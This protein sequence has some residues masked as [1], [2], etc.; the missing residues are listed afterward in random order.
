MSEVSENSSLFFPGT[1]LQKAWDSTSL[2]LAKECLR[3]YYYTIIE[4]WRSKGESVHLIFGIHFH[5]ALEIY[6]LHRAQGA[7]YET[8][9][10]EAVR[11]C[12]E[13]TWVR[14][15]RVQGSDTQ[16]STGMEE[17]EDEQVG[18]PWTP[19]HPAKTRSNLIRSV[20]WYLETYREDQVSTIILA[21]GKPAVELSFRFDSGIPSPGPDNYLLCG[22]MDRVV[23]YGGDQ[24]VMD[25]KTTGS[26]PGAYFFKGF[27]PDN[28][29]TLYTLASRVIY[30]APVKGVIIDAAQIAVGFTSFARGFTLRTSDQIEEWQEDLRT[31]LTIIENA[32]ATGA[33]PMNE[34]SCGNYGGCVFREVCSQQRNVREFYLKTNFEKRFWNPLEVR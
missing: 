4:G 28:Q 2:G 31:W 20:I 8:G 27:S 9:L 29:M 1:T 11:Y 34:K 5:K 33:Y 18:T 15:E 13:A 12:L 19:D 22:H 7:D 32:A 30:N 24:F 16:L 21:S 3:K 14:A 6:D 25:R 10:D 26:S 23:D 17:P